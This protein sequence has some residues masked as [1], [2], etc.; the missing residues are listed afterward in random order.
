MI[1]QIINNFDWI[2]DQPYDHSTL[3]ILLAIMGEGHN[4]CTKLLSQ[5]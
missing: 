4:L 3:E 2:D 1:D 5:K